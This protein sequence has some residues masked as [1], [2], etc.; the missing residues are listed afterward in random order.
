MTFSLQSGFIAKGSGVTIEYLIAKG[1]ACVEA[2]REITHRFATAFGHPDRTRRHSEVDVMQDLRLLCE[3]L[4]KARL[5]VQSPARLIL[6]H[7]EKSKKS[8]KQKDPPEPESAIVDAFE[9][10]SRIL[11]DGKFKLFLSSTCWD[12]AIGYPIST[13]EEESNIFISSDINPL[14]VDSFRDTDDGDNLAQQS[15]LGFGALGGG[16]EL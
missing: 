15:N 10:G 12:P 7:V 9:I 5:H 6:K 13:G 16:L 4:H 2:F 14:A 11:S 8:S 1:S 3:D